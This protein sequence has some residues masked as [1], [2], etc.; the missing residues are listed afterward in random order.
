MRR[1]L[2][3]IDLVIQMSDI[4]DKIIGEE[5]LAEQK[6]GQTMPLGSKAAKQKRKED[7]N[8]MAKLALG[9]CILAALGF[10]GSYFKVIA[11]SDMIIRW[12]NENMD[13]ANEV[14]NDLEDLKKKMDK[15]HPHETKE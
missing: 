6:R 1:F 11:A 14:S 12:Y 10:A 2:L 9:M 13:L 8:I 15:F 4:V 5:M 7:I 3:K